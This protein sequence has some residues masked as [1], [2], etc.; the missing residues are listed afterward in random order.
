M[1]WKEETVMSQRKEFVTLALKDGAN[2]SE[3]CRRL[4]ISRK[5]G[6]KWMRRY[7][8]GGDGGLEDLSRRPHR[9]PNRTSEEVE[10]AVVELR[11]EHP[12]K[13][14]HVLARMLRDR[15]IQDAPSKSTVAA[16][17]RRKGLIEPE[18]SARHTPYKRFERENPNDLWQ[19]DFKGHFPMI[20]DVRCHPLTLL[21]DHSRFSLGIRACLD[22]RGE[23]VQRHLEDVFRRYGL[24]VAIL[25]DNGPPWG[26]DPAHPFTP[27]TVWMMQLG[28]KVIH[29]RPRHPQTI[30]KLERFH[31]SLKTELLQGNV[32]AH[33]DHAQR[34]FDRWRD[35]YN[36]ERPHH[37]LGFDTPASRYVPSARPFPQSLPVIE[38]GHDDQ[39]RV[40]D[41]NGRISFRG[42][43]FRVGKAF[44]GKRVALRPSNADGAWTVFFS[45][46]PI[47]RVNFNS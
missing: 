36:L 1:P 9:S 20:D 16:I 2:V 32:Y 22:E 28:V 17:L 38:Y 23:T 27:L 29:S 13:G 24:P 43:A 42:R 14:A 3:E 11:L 10:Q 25:V 26:S 47:A 45:T 37:S 46:Q 18:G 12:K 44:R 8:E 39:V 41:A 30:G 31:L 33:V 7:Q 19:M 4:G 6:Y 21:D 5:T 15:G 40:V 35:F 34:S